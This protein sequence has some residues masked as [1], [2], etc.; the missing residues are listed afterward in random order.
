MCARQK[1]FSGGREHILLVSAWTCETSHGGGLPAR[2]A[3]LA[4]R[5]RA[6]RR[7]LFLASQTFGGECGLSRFVP[8]FF[9]FSDHPLKSI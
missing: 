9:C 4:R 8:C 7:R 3:V 1:M 2:G 5:K 6:G